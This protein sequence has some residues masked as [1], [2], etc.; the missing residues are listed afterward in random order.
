M[1]L[2]TGAFLYVLDGLCA[3]DF[4]YSRIRVNA[5]DYFDNFL[6]ARLENEYFHE[7]EMKEYRQEYFEDKPEDNVAAARKYRKAE[8][9]GMEN[10]NSQPGAG[11]GKKAEK[12]ADV[13]GSRGNC[14]RKR[15]GT[16]RKKGKES[17]KG[18][19]SS[20]AEHGGNGEGENY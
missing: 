2:L 11:S 18:A 9:S 15:G 17:Q 19:G 5:V 1:G 6:K 7:K 12:P 20:G 4:K 13:P 3:V 16:E 8:E 14:R 10:K